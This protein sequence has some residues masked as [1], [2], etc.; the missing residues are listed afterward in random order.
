MAKVTITTD[1][2]YAYESVERDA[3]DEAYWAL[4]YAAEE[5]NREAM[6]RRPADAPLGPPGVRD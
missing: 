2:G 6:K 1:F 4:I 3:P 5:L